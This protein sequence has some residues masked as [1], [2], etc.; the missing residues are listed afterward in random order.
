MINPREQVHEDWFP[1]LRLLYQEPLKTLSEEIL[2]NISYQPKDKDIFRV[3]EKPM[4]E[5]KVVILGQD[6]YP[7]PGNATGIAFSV[8]E[9]TRIPVSLRNIAQEVASSIEIKGESIVDKMQPLQF[10]NNTELYTE[11]KTLKHWQE[12]GVFLLNTALTVETGKAGSHLKYWEDFTK[13]IITTVC[14][15][16]PCIWIFWG[17]KAQQFIP[18]IHKNVFHVK[19]YDKETIENIPINSDWNYVLTAPHPAAE[20]YSG[21]KAGFF[22]CNHFHYV[23]SILKNKSLKEIK[24]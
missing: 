7:T 17:A 3:F 9:E 18:Y 22:G 24:W 16:Q 15:L 14:E 10:L 4:S 21:G 2:P 11:W 12:Q 8:T 20:A 19:G 6:P 13:K 5:I 1:L 23:N